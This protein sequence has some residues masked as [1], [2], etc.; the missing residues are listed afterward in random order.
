MDIEFDEIIEILDESEVKY[1]IGAAGYINVRYDSLS[2]RNQEELIRKSRQA[3]REEGVSV[4]GFIAPDLMYTYDTLL[5]AENNKIS[6]VI[7][8]SANETDPL[9]PE[10]VVGGKMN[11][12]LFPFVQKDIR[13]GFNLIFIDPSADS[14][15]L[16][17][18]FNEINSA[19]AIEKV[20]LSEKAD[21]IRKTERIKATLVTD[22]KEISSFIT[23]SNLLNGTKVEFITELG[24]ESINETVSNKTIPYH[25]SDNGFYVV[26]NDSTEQILI[27]WG[28]PE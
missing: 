24:V 27:K 9:H 7:L 18:Y 1:E 11:L 5:A 28:L 19:P 25:N 23:F 22:V 21:Y 2:Y 15:L 3:F 26:L 14:D 16:D 17:S 10:A 12:L 8:P 4:K 13:D 20:L 6:Y